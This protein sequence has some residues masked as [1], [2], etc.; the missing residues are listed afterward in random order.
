[1][2]RHGMM[3][4]HRVAL[5]VALVWGFGAAAETSLIIPKLQRIDLDNGIP[6][7]HIHM[8]DEKKY[9]LKVIVWGGRE[10][11]A[12]GFGNSAHVLEHLLFFQPDKERDDFVKEVTSKGGDYN[13]T[14]GCS[15]WEYF[16]T[17]PKDD[18][19]F[20][21]EWL[22]QVLDHETPEYEKLEEAK[23][24][25]RIENGWR[26][27]V[28]LERMGIV[29]EVLISFEEFVES[30]WEEAFGIEHEHYASGRTLRAITQNELE[31]QYK[32]YYV[33][34]NMVMLYA[35]PHSIQEV[36]DSTRALCGA[37]PSGEKAVL[38]QYR[39]SKVSDIYRN[40]ELLAS[41]T[42]V[43]V[44][45]LFAGDVSH[46]AR[47]RQFYSSVM[48]DLLMDK[49]RY[50]RNDTY[51]VNSS[52]TLF[53]DAGYVIFGLRCDRSKAWEDFDLL[54]EIVYGNLQTYLDKDDYLSYRS[55]FV[56]SIFVEPSPSG[57]L[58]RI[59]TELEDNPANEASETIIEDIAAFQDM[60]YEDFIQ[61]ATL[62]K[63]ATTHYE[64][65]H[66]GF[67]WSSA[68][69][70]LLYFSA[71]GNVLYVAAKRHKRRLP[72]E[73]TLNEPAVF[74]VKAVYALFQFVW[75]VYFVI[76]LE[77]LLELPDLDPAIEFRSILWI[78]T[79]IEG[80]VFGF[81][82]L[83]VGT[84]VPSRLL[85]DEK[86]L[87]IRT[88][89]W[90][91][92]RIP[93]DA[94]DKVTLEKTLRP[95]FRVRFGMLYL[96][97]WDYTFT[98]RMRQVFVHHHGKRVTILGV[99]KPKELVEFLQSKIDGCNPCVEERSAEEVVASV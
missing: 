49:F 7:Y 28:T 77:S 79:F 73:R 2:L 66:L 14:T 96:R 99:A 17:L 29:V 75:A 67:G 95:H 6:L 45:H 92:V 20:G 23:S 91:S 74:G 41:S 84:P 53:G 60:S 39:A 16:V 93:Y 10:V 76:W 44:G 62:F 37:L 59:E 90:R 31:E 88:M 18:L 1:M 63:D 33:A 57:M 22:F 81:L 87:Y 98:L 94:I 55:D 70:V 83:L 42:Y 21:A 48:E 52:N 24:V 36:L 26:D 47:F 3:S 38:K 12:E 72:F 30:F 68:F 8:P 64:R 61:E 40:N 15:S 34:E 43:S 82:W 65:F 58:Y 25:I 54:R 50:E 69:A 97:N 71:F 89:G 85:A 27:S 32:K 46:N 56:N 11:D 13:G 5:V 35:G 4:L 86:G 9:T 51:S 80:A 78:S 19:E